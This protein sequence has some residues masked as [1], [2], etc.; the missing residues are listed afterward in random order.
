MEELR[1]WMSPLGRYG[2]SGSKVSS[3]SKPLAR[4]L[5]GGCGGGGS[6]NVQTRALFSSILL[7]SGLPVCKVVCNYNCNSYICD[8]VLRVVIRLW[9]SLLRLI[10]WQFV[11]VVF[12]L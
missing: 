3:P 5:L 6:L 8:A 10:V 1:L 7:L 2:C 11:T 12:V 9:A 4:G